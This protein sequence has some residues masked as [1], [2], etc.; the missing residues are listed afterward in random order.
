IALPRAR[1]G[2]DGA[3]APPPLVDAWD[4]S[5]PQREGVI[6]LEKQTEYQFYGPNLGY[7]LELYERY[8][9]DRDSVDEGAREFFESWSPPRPNGAGANGSAATASGDIELDAQRAARAAHTAGR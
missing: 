7:V 6:R 2:G 9:E 5:R 3:C 1:R 8:R 4:S